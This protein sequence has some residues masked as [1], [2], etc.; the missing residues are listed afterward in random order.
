MGKG[1]EIARRP[2]LKQGLPGFPIP[3]VD[4]PAFTLGQAVVFPGHPQCGGG[5]SV[6]P[7]ILGQKRHIMHLTCTFTCMACVE[8]Q[9]ER[10]KDRSQSVK[11]GIQSIRQHVSHSFL[12]PVA[13]L[14]AQILNSSSKHSMKTEGKLE[15]R[16]IA[17]QELY[18]SSSSTS[19]LGRSYLR[20]P[21]SKVYAL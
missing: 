7:L 3:R 8:R 20:D 5:Q 15:C 14:A 13:Q 18:V 12:G 21:P 9:R 4:K 17:G 16:F 10:N 6:A 11:A 1:A 19:G 2:Q